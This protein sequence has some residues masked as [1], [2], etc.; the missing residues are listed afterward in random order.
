MLEDDGGSGLHLRDLKLEDVAAYLE[1]DP[2]LL[3]ILLRKLA[4]TPSAIEYGPHS[5]VCITKAVSLT[6]A[7][8]ED[9]LQGSGDEI[10]ELEALYDQ[11]DIREHNPQ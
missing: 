6:E 5:A 11:Q 3:R 9:Y 2:R 4:N 10:T 7:E 1:C 8:L